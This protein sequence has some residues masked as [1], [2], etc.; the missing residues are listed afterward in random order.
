[1][2]NSFEKKTYALFASA[3]NKKLIGDLEKNNC[4]VF[5]F[6]TLETEKIFFDETKIEILMEITRF[7]WII[8][9]DVYS[10]EFF[11]Q[12]LDENNIDYFEIDAIK[13]CALGEA[14]SDTLRF[15]QLH[16]DVIPHSRQTE[17]IFSAI[18]DYL[19][20]DELKKLKFLLVKEISQTCELVEKLKEND[21]E[22]LELSVYQAK[23]SEKNEIVRLKTLLSGGAI[24]EFVFSSAAD[25]AALQFYFAGESIVDSLAEIQISATSEIVF[26]TA[27]ELNLR[28][29]YFHL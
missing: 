19:Y 2:A 12:A 9:T 1:M 16:A 11:L 22:V 26:Q 8:F 20:S 4:K 15:V 13:V 23:F 10:V 5:Q 18:K 7:D 6:P 14:V 24:D 27:R 3:A 21:A 29:L 17:N 25:F 28:P